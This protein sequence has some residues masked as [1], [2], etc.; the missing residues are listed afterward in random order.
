MPKIKWKNKTEIEQEKIIADTEKQRQ[1]RRVLAKE[2]AA[3]ISVA[4]LI[5]SEGLTAEEVEEVTYLFN[6]F[7]VGKSYIV[8]DM[9]VC[10]DKLYKVVQAHTSQSDWT[11]DI[12]ASLFTV[13]QAQGVIEE[14]GTRN[15]TVN[16]F[17]IGEQVRFEGVVYES[18]IDNNVWTP[19]DYPQG[20]K[21]I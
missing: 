6:E 9:L 3:K 13:V 10:N 2:K 5:D 18:T 17:M 19:A 16:P 21:V 1:E 7:E 15:L 12:T 11:P 4:K 20:W 14:W 8:G